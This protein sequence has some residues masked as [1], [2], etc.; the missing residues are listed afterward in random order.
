[1]VL[2]P[3]AAIYDEFAQ[4][5]NSDLLN[6]LRTSMGK[7]S[8]ALGIIISTQAAND[9]HP[10]SQLVDDAALGEDPSV[11]LQLAAAPVDADIF[12]EKTW[13]AC[14]EALGKYLDLSEFRAQAGQAKRLPSLRAKFENLRLNK[15]IDANLQYISDAD[16]MQ[17]AA[18]PEIKELTGKPVLRR[19]RSFAD[20]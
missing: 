3:R 20:N 13:F 9:Q 12:D 4:A 11:Y 10:L 18:P 15:R 14:N 8:E 2:H 19:I 5:P 7:R 16:W 1:M 6:S 17:C